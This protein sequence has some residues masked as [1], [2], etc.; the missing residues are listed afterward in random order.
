[1]AT[2]H[3]PTVLAIGGFDPYGG[4]GTL[5]DT[6]T[7]HALGGY[8]LSAITAITAQNS[9]GVA[10]VETVSASLL[11]TQLSVLL[12]DIRVD[13]VKI[14]MLGDASLVHVVADIIK[15]YELPNVVLD[16]VLVSSSGRRLLEPEAVEV[17]VH[18]LFPL[19]RLITPNLHE[20]NTLLGT[21]YRG[22]MKDVLAMANGL[23][24]MGANAVLL[25]GG[26]SIEE[27]AVDCL[28]DPSGMHSISTPRVGTIHTHGTGCLLSSAIATHLAQGISLKSSVEGAKNFL[29]DRLGHADTLSLN[30]REKNVPRSEAI[31]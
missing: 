20:T 6:K 7:I 29:Y 15:Q 31:F 21:V 5:I 2:E 30:Y 1:M 26:H 9:Q 28:V 11:R 8:A 25:K 10:A 14:G 24:E 4:A 16:P 18:R 3:T 19:C 13:A 22:E 17:M 12:N 27:E 23:F